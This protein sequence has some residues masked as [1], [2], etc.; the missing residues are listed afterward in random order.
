MRAPSKP[1]RRVNNPS[2]GEEGWKE[3]GA[4]SFHILS[5]SI[6]PGSENE[7]H[8]ANKRAKSEKERRFKKKSEQQEKTY[9]KHATYN[10]EETPGKAGGE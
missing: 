3:G 9:E 6:R 1:N 10:Y 7:C 4:I 5:S 8:I 2:I